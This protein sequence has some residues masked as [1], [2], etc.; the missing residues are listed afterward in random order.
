MEEGIREIFGERLEGR[1]AAEG[2]GD[3]TAAVEHLDCWSV[4][5]RTIGRQ[6]DFSNIFTF[7]EHAERGAESLAWSPDQHRC[8]CSIR[9]AYQVS[10]YIERCVV[11]PLQ[12]IQA[13]KS[14]PRTCSRVGYPIPLFHQ[15]LQIRPDVRLELGNRLGAEDMRDDLPLASVLGAV[16][17][18]EGTATHG[19]KGFV[20]LAG[21][22]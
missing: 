22:L 4:C 12:A 20:E 9:G 14:I 16:S 17:C 3:F 21:I 19:N 11:E 6:A 2:V 1:V 18:A 5:G 7:G 8:F 13:H 15:L 10:N